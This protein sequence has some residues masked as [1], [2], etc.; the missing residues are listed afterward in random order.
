MNWI[1]GI[2]GYGAGYLVAWLGA[3]NL[4][5]VVSAL[6]LVALSMLALERL[7]RLHPRPGLQALPDW[8]K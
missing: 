4:W 1:A 3:G 8:V 5:V 7:P 6:P 2:L